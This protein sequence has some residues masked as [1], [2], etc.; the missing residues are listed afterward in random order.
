MSKTQFLTEY[1]YNI[2]F[3]C[4]PFTKCNNFSKLMHLIINE[5]IIGIKKIKEHFAIRNNRKKINYKNKL[6]WTALMIACRNCKTWSSLSTIE[7]LLKY[8]ADVNLKTNNGYTALMKIVANTKTDS[9]ISAAKLLIG[10]GANVNETTYSNETA[11]M[12]AINNINSGSNIETVKLLLENGA[13]PNLCNNQKKSSITLAIESENTELTKL[14]INSANTKP[15]VMYE[16]IVSLLNIKSFDLEKLKK[17]FQNYANIDLDNIFMYAIKKDDC[18]VVKILLEY[19]VNP[20]GTNSL[21]EYY[22]NPLYYLSQNPAKNTI[23]LTDLLIEY[24]ANINLCNCDGW[25]PLMNAIFEHNFNMAKYLLKKGADPNLQSNVSKR[26]SLYLLFANMKNMTVSSKNDLNNMLELLLEY[27]A[28]PN[29][30]TIKGKTVLMSVAK[31]F[32]K[33]NLSMALKILL[34]SRAYVNARDN[35][36]NTALIFAAKKYRWTVGNLDGIIMLLEYGADYKL[37]NNKKNNCFS[38]SIQGNNLSLC[39]DVIKKMAIKKYIH[40]LLCKEIHQNAHILCMNPDSIRTKMITI[41]WYMKNGNIE[42]II[43]WKNLEIINCVSDYVCAHDYNDL[44]DKISEIM[45]HTHW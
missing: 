6:G 40:S 27:G 42:N 24:G 22:C 35:L 25:T 31:K 32:T 37:E 38:Y 33:H 8:K 18:N 13:D 23:V 21:D 2:K 20:N 7:I 9:S 4:D 44:R 28:N 11:L 19:G 34:D 5:H 15:S 26:T 29:L 41:D 43:T 3:P 12:I 17:F 39:V 30:P 36:G 10:A 1:G 16:I 14:L 45:R